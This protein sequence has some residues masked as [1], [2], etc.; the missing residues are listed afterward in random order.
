MFIFCIS[1]NA[2]NAPN[3][4]IM[5]TDDYEHKLYEDYLDQGYTVV[6]KIF[7]VNCPPCNTIAPFVQNLYEQWGEGAYDVQFIELSNKSYDSNEDVA[8]YKARHG[9]TFPGAGVDGNAMVALQPYLNGTFGTFFGTPKFA[10]ISPDRSVNFN[11]GG[12]GTQGRI[13]AL[14]AAIAATG[15]TGMAQTVLPSNYQINISDLFNNQ[16][17]GFE[18][19]LQSGVDSNIEYPVN[20]SN[21]FSFS[22]TDINAEYPQLVDPKIIIRKTDEVK[23]KLSAID[24]LII[25]KHI[26]GVES[27]GSDLLKIA[28]DT[29]AD[30]SISAIDLLALQRIILGINSTFPNADS[31]QFIPS[32]F[33]LLI[34]AGETQSINFTAI[35]TGDLNGF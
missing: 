32:E 35:K 25:M 5:D 4:T 17:N 8:F 18:L 34:Q 22:I 1:S 28:A 13:D 10:V 2:Q 29:N 19:F 26:L 3:F 24:L 11:V 31:Y 30:G 12:S 15:A 33:P 9:I 27:L 23:Q 14:D 16:V 7:F 20:L 21:G 6:I